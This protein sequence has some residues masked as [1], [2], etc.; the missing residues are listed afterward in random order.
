MQWEQKI[1]VE[2][3]VAQRMDL[4]CGFESVEESVE[5]MNSRVDSL[6]GLMVAIRGSC[7]SLLM[8]KQ[9]ADRKSQEIATESPSKSSRAFA[10]EL[11]STLT[12][13]VRLEELYVKAK[14]QL[15]QE[16]Q[17]YSQQIK[18]Q[19][20]A[21]ASKDSEIQTLKSTMA[22]VLSEAAE[23]LDSSPLSPPTRT[24]N[25]ELGASAPLSVMMLGDESGA[26][27]G[28]EG[29][30]GGG[31]GDGDDGDREAGAGAGAGGLGGAGAGAGA[32]GGGA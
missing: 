30:G 4:E 3:H 29:G 32:S 8:E 16:R 13:V 31:G 1:L 17:K 20:S 9:A 21:L 14:W 11:N 22:S 2:F 7:G 5:E 25:Y 12:D 19:K 10:T 27:C 26:D 6:E 28:G 24:R 23:Y 18:A 15:E